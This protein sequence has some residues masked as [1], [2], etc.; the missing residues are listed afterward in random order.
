MT[1]SPRLGSSGPRSFPLGPAQAERRT[2][3]RG[4]CH[5]ALVPLVFTIILAGCGKKGPPEP[6][7]GEPATYPRPYPSE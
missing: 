5:L 3:E 6:P 7:P 2:R 1:L 4:F